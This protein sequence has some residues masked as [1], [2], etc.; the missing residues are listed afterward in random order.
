MSNYQKQKESILKWR[1]A[2]IDN[3]RLYQKNYSREHYEEINKEK[4]RLYY[5]QNKEKKHQY[6][7][8]KKQ[9]KEDINDFMNILLD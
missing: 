9:Y 1:K 8:A 2:N 4:K 6:Y 3:Y 7:L 5:L